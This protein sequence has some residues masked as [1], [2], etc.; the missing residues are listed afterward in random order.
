M[1]LPDKVLTMLSPEDRER[2]ERDFTLYGNAFVQLLGDG[3]HAVYVPY[4]QI[5]SGQV[6]IHDSLEL[7]EIE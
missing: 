7:G 6:A 1:S 2:V 3:H 5:V 4:V